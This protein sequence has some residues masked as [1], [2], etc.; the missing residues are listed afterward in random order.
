M[1]LA[2]ISSSTENR[3]AQAYLP[4]A[5]TAWIGLSRN[6]WTWSDKSQ[7]TFRNWLNEE[8]TKLGKNCALID[9]DLQSRWVEESCSETLPFL[10]YTDDEQTTGSITGKRQI[11]SVELRSDHNV[12][13]PAVKESILEMILQELKQHGMA[14]NTTLTWRLQPDG[15]IFQKKKNKE[16]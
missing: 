3:D 2:S 12:N 13:D 9:T 15:N 8:P 7:S 6:A 1:D 16:L 11:L 14:E 4:A 10:C 5:I